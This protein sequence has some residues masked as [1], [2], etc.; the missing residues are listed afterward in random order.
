MAR[1]GHFFTDPK[2]GAYCQVTLDSGEKIIVRHAPGGFT[3][4]LLT[5]E[6]WRWLRLRSDR[7]FTCDLDGERGRIA[8]ARL[9]H[10]AIPGSTAA[11]PLRALVAYVK[12]G[13]SVAGVKIRCAALIA[14][15]ESKRT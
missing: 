6:T 7:I 10:D 1:V 2:R 5:I 3:G 11:L 15:P 8:L 4:G 9:T 14:G 13:G 12:D